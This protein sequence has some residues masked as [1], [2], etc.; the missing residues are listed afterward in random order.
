HRIANRFTKE[1]AGRKLRISSPQGR[2]TD[3]HLVSGK[4]L[5]KAEA[6]GK[7][8]FL[9]FGP[10]IVRIHLGIYGKWSFQS[11]DKVAPEPVGQVRARFQIPDLLADL[12][13]P[14]ACEVIDQDGYINALSKLGPDPIKKDMNSISSD[15]FVKR[16]R[17]SSR[18]IAE[19]LMDQSVIAGV[20]NVYRAELLFRAK[21]NPFVAGKSVPKELVESIWDDAARLMPIGVRT[22]LMLTRDGFLSGKPIMED[23][24]YVYKREC[25]KCRECGGK[26]SI[27]VLAG[28]KLYWCRRCQK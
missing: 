28:R 1:F 21:L 3:A 9:G 13:G 19:L 8:L 11:F 25:E 14:T 2:F 18:S 23:R 20:G 15:Q 24:Y 26:V 27:Q 4:K 22:G 10:E 6:H 16:V 7:Q 17:S 12:R 5:L